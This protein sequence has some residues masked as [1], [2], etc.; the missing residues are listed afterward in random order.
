MEY[1]A[2]AIGAFALFAIVAL[3][4]LERDLLQGFARD[5]SA[6]ADDLKEGVMAVGGLGDAEY[7]TTDGI[8]RSWV[9]HVHELD[10]SLVMALANTGCNHRSATPPTDRPEIR[11]L[12][13]DATNRFAKRYAAHLMYETYPGVVVGAYTYLLSWLP[14]KP[15]RPKWFTSAMQ[16]CNRIDAM[17]FAPA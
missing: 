14:K 10:W 9:I 8:I 13:D 3:R 2:L 17:L 12:I 11:L 5:L 7:K 6:I 4:E 1:V 15:R 16:C